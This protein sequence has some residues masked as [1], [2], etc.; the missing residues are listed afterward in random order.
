M[1]SEINEVYGGMKPCSDVHEEIVEG[2]S[3]WSHDGQKGSEICVT[4]DVE[5]PRET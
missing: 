4:R 5:V 1:L 3:R 2:S